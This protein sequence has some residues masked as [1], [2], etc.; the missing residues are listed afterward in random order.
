MVGVIGCPHGGVPTGATGD[1]SASAPLSSLTVAVRS[2]L[3]KTSWA[4]GC[5]TCDGPA[6]RE[7]RRGRREC[8]RGGAD[9]AEVPTLTVITPSRSESTVMVVPVFGTFTEYQPG[10]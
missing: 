6:G 8:R 9:Q 10:W 2:T 5:R 3:Q 1:W 4:T 7:V